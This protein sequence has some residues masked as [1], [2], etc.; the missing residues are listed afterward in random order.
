MNKRQVIAVL[1]ATV[2]LTMIFAGGLTG[3]GRIASTA[4]SLLQFFTLDRSGGLKIFPDIT[5]AHL[6]PA[7][8]NIIRLTRQEFLAQSPGTK[9]SEG[10]HEAWCADFVSWIMKE[11]GAPMRNQNSG[12]WRIPGTYTLLDYYKAEGRLHDAS[13]DYAPKLGDVA[14]YRCG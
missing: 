10:V 13:S 6:S 5:D 14:I 4:G 12:S 1:V 2:I 7:E 11:S 9:F 8:Q 3:Y